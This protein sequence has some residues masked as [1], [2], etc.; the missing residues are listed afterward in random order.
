MYSENICKNVA[1][2]S[3][4]SKALETKEKVASCEEIRLVANGLYIAS[5]LNSRIDDVENEMKSLIV[6]IKLIQVEWNTR[7]NDIHDAV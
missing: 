4:Q 3:F 1:L 2:V 6:T 5:D 7:D